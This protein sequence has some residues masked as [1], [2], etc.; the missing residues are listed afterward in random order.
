MKSFSQKASIILMTIVFMVAI[1]RITSFSILEEDEIEEL[2]ENVA[3]VD[4]EENA[5]LLHW[6][7]SDLEI[8]LQ[9]FKRIEFQ[10]AVKNRLKYL[11]PLLDKILM[12]PE[13]LV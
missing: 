3:D 4:D 6:S 10:T 9:T 11:N 1:L 2:L 5:Y 13:K 7:F 8:K 12:P